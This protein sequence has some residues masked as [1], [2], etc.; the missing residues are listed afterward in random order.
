MVLYEVTS[1]TA[2]SI[3]A[4]I[5]YHYEDFGKTD[6]IVKI[7]FLVERLQRNWL[8]C[9]DLDVMVST[10]YILGKIVLSVYK[11]KAF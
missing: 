4:K 3:Q 5:D 7:H 10:E 2:T 8:P 9:H 6:G 11:L 1:F